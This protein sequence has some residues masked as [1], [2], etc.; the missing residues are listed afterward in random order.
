MEGHRVSTLISYR[1][2][3]LPWAPTGTQ[4]ISAASVAGSPLE[5]R[6]SLPPTW[7][8]WVCLTSRLAAFG[9]APELVGP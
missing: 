2:W 4:S 8:P 9:P 1:R 3:S 5:T 6:V 7:Q